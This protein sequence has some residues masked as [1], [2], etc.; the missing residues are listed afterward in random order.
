MADLPLLSPA[1]GQTPTLDAHLATKGYVDT[2]RN[3]AGLRTVTAGTTLV[4]GDAGGVVQVNATTTQTV[5]V[6]A[7]ASVAHP[8]NT[9]AWVRKVGTGNVTVVGATGVTVNWV[10]GNFTV[11]AQYASAELHKVATDTWVGHVHT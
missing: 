6:P 4:T 10:G 1:T 8:V 11:S 7:N 9:R 2:T 3:A 5:T